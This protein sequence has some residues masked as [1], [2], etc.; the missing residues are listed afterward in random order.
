MG[1]TGRLYG[2][3]AMTFSLHQLLHLAEAVQQLGP[4][5][6]HSAFE[7]ESGNGQLVKLVK[8]SNALPERVV[9]Y[10]QLGSNFGVLAS[11]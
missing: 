3:P 6:G 4:L 7:F 9:K 2:A 11:K 1:M 10:Q 5:W 8:G